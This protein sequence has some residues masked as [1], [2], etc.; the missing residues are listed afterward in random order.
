MSLLIAR[1]LRTHHT[2]QREQYGYPSI[3]LAGEL[4]SELLP[5]L[6][7]YCP[8]RQQE[9]RLAS[10][11]PFGRSMF[12]FARQKTSGASGA[13]WKT[14]CPKNFKH[15]TLHLVLGDRLPTGYERVSSMLPKRPFHIKQRPVLCFIFSPPRR[16]ILRSIFNVFF[17]VMETF[18]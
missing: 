11:R 8:Q 3:V 14:S 17:K 13:G 5:P 2:A 6:L 12:E 15:H 9:G 18:H 1:K 10:A 16:S 4:F 7:L